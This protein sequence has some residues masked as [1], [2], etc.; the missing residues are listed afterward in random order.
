MSATVSLPESRVIRGDRLLPSRIEQ[1]LRKM[2]VDKLTGNVILNIKE[3]RI[4]GFHKTEIE[5]IPAA[6]IF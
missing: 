3:G 2:Q 1:V 5:T 6:E 4:L